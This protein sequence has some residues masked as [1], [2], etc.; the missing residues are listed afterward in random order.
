MS[1]TIFLRTPSGEEPAVV[2]NT[3]RVA[4]VAAEVE[5]PQ[6]RACVT[7]VA[8]AF[9]HSAACHGTQA[10]AV[11]VVVNGSEFHETFEASHLSVRGF[12]WDVLDAGAASRAMYYAG[13]TLAMP[14]GAARS[15]MP[16]ESYVVADDGIRHLCD[17]D[18]WVFM[19]PLAPAPFLPLRPF[20]VF[21]DEWVHHAAGVLSADGLRIV[22]ENLTAAAGVLV[23]SD[24][25]LQEMVHFYGVDRERVRLLPRL[26]ACGE[27]AMTASGSVRHPSVTDVP[28][29]QGQVWFVSEASGLSAYGS[30]GWSR[31]AEMAGS[32]ENAW[33]ENDEQLA[34][35][36]GEALAELL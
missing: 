28:L 23:W 20:L 13:P 27:T 26:S 15:R 1:D 36:Y 7:A 12:T 10:E 19:S 33:S 21:A 14:A 35:A 32:A 22:A 18:A 31:V 4:V 34:V 25:M 5:R 6:Q 3:V 17:C 16:L 11:L 29:E 2:R 9:H 8:Q 30:A 24:D